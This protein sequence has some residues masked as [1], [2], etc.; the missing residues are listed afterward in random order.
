LAAY[1]G[2]AQAQFNYGLVLDHGDGIPTDKSLAAHYYKLAAD[3][4]LTG[5]RI[6]YEALLSGDNP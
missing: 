4:G 1:Q 3:Q 2:D 6:N 5:A